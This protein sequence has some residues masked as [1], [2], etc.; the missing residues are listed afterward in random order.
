MRVS[1]LPLAAKSRTRTRPA[2]TATPAVAALADLPPGLGLAGALALLDRSGLTGYDRV[3]VLRATHRQV[4]HYQAMLLSDMVAV[5][6]CELAAELDPEAAAE[7]FPDEIAAALAWTRGTAAGQLNL[8]WSLTRRLPA[9][10]AALWCGL[11][12]LPKARVFC[13]ETVALHESAARVVCGRVLPDA[14]RLTTRQLKDRLQREVLVIDADAAAVRER[15]AIAGRRVWHERESDGTATI[16]LLGLPADRAAAAM[17]R[18]DAIAR[19]ASLT[20]DPRTLDQV[21]VDTVL[22]LLDGGSILE[23]HPTPRKGVVDLRVPLTTL[24]GLSEE[25]GEFARLGSRRG[26]LGAEDRR[27]AGQ[28]R[29]AALHVDGR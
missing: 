6:E 22:D 9:V 16:T 4:A 17:E 12:D 5:G 14:P 15:D 1:D 3:L 18:V 24:L 8:G 26:D 13:R 27:R 11:I 29:A 10:H 7:F 19:T 20:G 21:R 2:P 23:P 25:P 28:R